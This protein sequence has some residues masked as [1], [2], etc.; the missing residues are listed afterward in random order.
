MTEDTFDAYMWATLENKQK[1][2]GQIMTSKS[3]VRSAE[4][5]D[6]TAL[7]YA[8]VKA[9]ATGDER[10]KEKMDL[11]VSVAKLK[12][13]RSN[14]LTQ[15]YAMEDALIKH[16]PQEVQKTEGKIAGYRAD[17]ERLSGQQES[18]DFP[19]MVLNGI[20]YAEKKDAGVALLET[21]KA[22]TSPESK[23]VGTYRGFDLFLSFD[24]FTRT[25]QVAL[26]GT[27]S[28]TADLGDD[29]YGNMQRLDNTLKSMPQRLQKCEQQL[30]D[31]H[32]QMETARV[33]VQKPFPQELEL[34]EKCARLAE[35]DAELNIDKGRS[36]SAAALEDADGEAPAQE[37]ECEADAQ[38]HSSIRE[39]LR[40][41]SEEQQPVSREHTRDFDREER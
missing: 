9:L 27:L 30:S 4:D 28:H 8:E 37:Q 22:Q 13:V 7:T 15:K 2:I 18:D 29:L 40:Q 25:F 33:E 16:F 20:S 1:F 38:E 14:Y 21:C 17:M 35:L 32:Q 3:P 11:E 26:K 31:L 12:L 10:I 6:E 24:A 36:E 41:Y 5:V 23:Q 19:G 39:S 34:N